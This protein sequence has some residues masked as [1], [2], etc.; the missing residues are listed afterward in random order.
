M[1]SFRSAER[2]RAANAVSEARRTTPFAA[3]AHRLIRVHPWLPLL[4][5]FPRSYPGNPRDPR[6]PLHVRRRLEAGD[7]RP[8]ITKR[9]DARP[10]APCCTFLIS[11]LQRTRGL[12]PL[13]I[14]TVCRHP[15]TGHSSPPPTPPEYHLP[16]A[17]APV[18]PLFWTTLAVT[19]L[20]PRIYPGKSLSY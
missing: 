1:N 14:E 19:I 18:T 17:A 9:R 20:F 10:I 6:L 15:R 16:F 4:S 13:V 5:R 2:L 12:C 11:P 8:L 3:P 7:W